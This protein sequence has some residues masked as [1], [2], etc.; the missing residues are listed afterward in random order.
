MVT[1]DP[2]SHRTMDRQDNLA[3]SVSPNYSLTMPLDD[4]QKARQVYQMTQH[5]GTFMPQ[6]DVGMPMTHP[7]TSEDFLQA[8]NPHIHYDHTSRGLMPSSSTDSQ[9]NGSETSFYA[10]NTRNSISPAPTPNTSHVYRIRHSI[11]RKS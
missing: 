11:P 6:L 7:A 3:S 5:L 4:I 1:Q 8:E 10:S 2:T 9:S